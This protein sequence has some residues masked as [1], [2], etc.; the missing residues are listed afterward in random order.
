M[1]IN[2]ACTLLLHPDASK[3]TLEGVAQQVG[4]NN[5]QTFNTAFKRVVG[6]TPGNFVKNAPIAEIVTN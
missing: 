5:R 2:V 4:F 6:V 3:V 1:R